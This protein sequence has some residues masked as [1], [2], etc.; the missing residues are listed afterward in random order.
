MFGVSVHHSNTLKD[1]QQ[2][3]KLTGQQ[4]DSKHMVRFIYL[5]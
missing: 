1:E 2:P 5:T 3:H 4:G